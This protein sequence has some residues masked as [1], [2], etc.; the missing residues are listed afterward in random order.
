MQRKL[1][2]LILMA[3]C[4][5][6]Y[7][8]GDEGIE[9]VLHDIGAAPSVEGIIGPVPAHVKEICWGKD[10]KTLKAEL[11][12]ALD[13]L[14]GG[15]YTNEDGER[16]HDPNGIRADSLI[17][18]ICLRRE[19]EAYYTKYISAGGVAI[20]GNGY[21]DDRFFYAAREIV[22]GMT[23]K[24]PE[25]RPLLT[26]SREN[27]PGATQNSIRHDVTG[28]T[29]LSP[30]YR[31]ILV[32]V[33]QGSTVAPENHL[34]NG[35]IS[36]PVFEIG[37]HGSWGRVVVQMA[38]TGDNL[39]FAGVFIHEFAHAIHEAIELLD[40]TFDARLEAAY[41]SAKENGSYF[42]DGGSGDYALTTK[43]EYWAES[44]RLWFFKFA[45][46][47][48]EHPMELFREKD[49]LM[50]ELLDEWFD[51]IY[52]RPVESKVYE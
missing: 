43:W 10:V 12:N 35:V 6:V 18:Q 2:F 1:L 15:F 52:L 33:H 19:Q 4:F 27:R 37:T 30:K 46:P 25:L 23:Q 20:M 47:R 8:C 26:P 42:G 16:V 17:H 48:N 3:L 11:E 32:H 45:N 29:T 5:Y 9:T 40:T 13:A 38:P 41:A 51:L 36:Y 49:P 22:L 31:M 21:I 39:Y 7:G 24:R 50:Y 28:R 44:A 34:R 14:D